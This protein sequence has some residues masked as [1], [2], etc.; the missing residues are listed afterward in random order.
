MLNPLRAGNR[1]ILFLP[2]C[3]EQSLYALKYSL[4][5]GE[6]LGRLAYWMLLHEQ[7]KLH[8]QLR[9]IFLVGIELEIPLTSFVLQFLSRNW[10]DV[11]CR[12]SPKLR[13]SK[14]EKPNNLELRSFGR[15]IS[16]FFKFYQNVDRNRPSSSCVGLLGYFILI[17]SFALPSLT[18][19]HGYNGKKLT[20]HFRTCW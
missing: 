5:V 17:S 12:I 2:C 1:S 13:S 8:L 7:L 6:I 16:T 11:Q 14:Q 10:N 18:S 20:I 9:M 15:H 3:K 4:V 19:T